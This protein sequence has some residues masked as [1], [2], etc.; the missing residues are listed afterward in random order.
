MVQLGR[1]YKTL[2]AISAVN[3]DG[4]MSTPSRIHSGFPYCVHISMSNLRIGALYAVCWYTYA[5]TLAEGHSLHVPN[6]SIA[7]VTVTFLLIMLSMTVF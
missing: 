6:L 4:R 1:Q 3:A 2:N 7:A 5:M